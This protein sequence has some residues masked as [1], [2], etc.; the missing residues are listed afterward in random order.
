[1]HFADQPYHT[2][3]RVAPGD[4]ATGLA[5]RRG[6]LNPGPV[7]AYPPNRD[8]FAKRFGP[9]F[10]RLSQDFKLFQG[11][12]IYIPWR[13]EALKNLVVVFEKLSDDVRKDTEASIE[14]LMKDKEDL[15]AYLTKLDILAVASGAVLGTFAAAGVY[16]AELSHVESFF[17]KKIFDNQVGEFLLGRFLNVGGVISVATD[18]PSPVP[19]K[20]DTLRMIVRH[21]LNVTS[22]SY[23]AAVIVAIREGDSDIWL[24]GPG[25]IAQDRVRAIKARARHEISDLQNG[26]TAAKRQLAL[27]FYRYRM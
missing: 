15:E 11:D 16:A 10:L 8:L 1:M 22:P 27:P 5:T 9:G 14:E 13:E 19:K 12:Y 20:W 6:F 26:V 25:R 18:A 23:W 7:V 17:L 3:Y 4:T 21:T 24:S 2:K